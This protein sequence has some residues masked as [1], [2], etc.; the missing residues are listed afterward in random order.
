M[1]EIKQDQYERGIH[2]QFMLMS[3]LAVTGWV[4]LLLLPSHSRL[5]PMSPRSSRS[6]FIVFLLLPGLISSQLESRISP[7]R[8]QVTEELGQPGVH[9]IINRGRR[10][11]K[12]ICSYKIPFVSFFNQNNL[13]YV[14]GIKREFIN[15]VFDQ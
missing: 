1:K 12:E 7:S 14:I 2:S 9:N 15:L 11:N 8:V 4:W 6:S 13:K 5:V 10:K 3:I